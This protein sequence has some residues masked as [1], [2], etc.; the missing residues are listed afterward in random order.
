M[1]WRHLG[2]AAVLVTVCSCFLKQDPPPQPVQS[3]STVVEGVI[4]ME[5][6][7][8]YD[9]GAALISADFWQQAKAAASARAFQKLDR[10]HERLNRAM[11][12]DTAPQCQ[13]QHATKS[14]A[15][16]TVDA[17]LLSA[18]VITFG[19]ALQTGQLALDQDSN[20]SYKRRLDPNVPAGIYQIKVGGSSEVPGFSMNVSMP[21]A[22]QNVVFLIGDGSRST[23]DIKRDKPLNIGWKAPAVA[24]TNTI[25]IAD[26]YADTAHETWRVRCA[27][28]ESS[29]TGGAG[30]LTWTIGSSLLSQLPTTNDAQVYL[31]R[32]HLFSAQGNNIDIQSQGMRIFLSEATID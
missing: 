6:L 24:N 20:G 19:A 31:M 3:G 7:Q 30:I 25:M 23:V 22:L 27:A 15:P 2:L 9:N 10:G 1:K 12:R 26:V 32:A 5:D 8:T 4:T 14:D 28:K 18:G 29:M 21:E 13:V 16:A 17:K 11:V